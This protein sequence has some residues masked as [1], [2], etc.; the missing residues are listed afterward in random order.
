MDNRREGASDRGAAQQGRNPEVGGNLASHQ[1]I[2]HKSAGWRPLCTIFGRTAL[3]CWASMTLETARFVVSQPTP[4]AERIG[5]YVLA[6]I[7]GL[8]ICGLISVAK[9][10]REEAAR[11]P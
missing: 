3:T 2:Y 11:R 8:L 1:A 7:V 5:V 4:E 6:A 10:L 9:E